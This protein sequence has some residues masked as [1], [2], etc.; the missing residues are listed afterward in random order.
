MRKNYQPTITINPGDETIC[1][2]ETANLSVSGY[3]PINGSFSWSNGSTNSNIS[4]TPN[5]TTSYSVSFSDQCTQNPNFKTI[6]VNP[7]PI[8]DLSGVDDSYCISDLS[9]INLGSN[10]IPSGGTWTAA[11]GQNF[12]I[13]SSGVF[14]PSQYLLPNT[15]T[16]TYTYQN[17]YGCSAS[18]NFT[19]GYYFNPTLSATID[20]VT[21]FGDGDGAI[22]TVAGGTGPYNFTINGTTQTPPFTSLSGG[23]YS[24]GVTDGHGC[25]TTNN[26]TVNEAS[27]PITAS[28]NQPNPLALTCPG[29]NTNVGITNVTGGI[30]PY[31][32]DFGL[33]GGYANPSTYSLLAGKS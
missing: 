26:Y 13:S 8:I 7:N 20:D 2:G 6:T 32:Y 17:S 11:P 24:I 1:N 10:A 19:F 25:T 27:A 12:T 15:F 3:S 21:C 33:G 5:Q 31:T 18:Q 29:F 30:A 16:A 14:D 9:L 23:N 22:Y 4:V 28:F